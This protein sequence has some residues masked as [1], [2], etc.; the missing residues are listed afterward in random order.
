MYLEEKKQIEDNVVGYVGS[1][2]DDIQATTQFSEELRTIILI[3]QIF[4]W[5][6]V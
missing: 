5:G 1:T 4:L 2:Y 3:L 6:E